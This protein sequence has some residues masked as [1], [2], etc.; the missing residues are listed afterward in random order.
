M[1]QLGFGKVVHRALPGL[2]LGLALCLATA[3]CGSNKSAPALPDSDAA[4]ADGGGDAGAAPSARVYVSVAADNQ[5][6]VIDEQ[7]QKLLKKV[8]V[9]MGPAILL[10][11]PDQKKLYTANWADNSVSAIVVDTLAVKNIKVSSRPYVIATDPAGKYLYAGLQ[12][13]QIDVIDIATDKIARSITT[14]D[15]PA[16]I[17]VSP[18]GKTLYVATFSVLGGLGGTV[19]AISADKGAVTHAS[20]A[21][22]SVPAWIS[23]SPDG[24]K[25]FT[26]NFLSDDI[27]VVDTAA[28]KV[29]ATVSTGAGSQ[30]IIGNVT[31]DGKTLYV[32]NH[33]THEL[34]AIDVKTN[35]VAQTIPLPGR[36]VGVSF[37][38]DGSRVYV[39]DFG[40]QSLNY[41]ADTNYLLTGKLTPHGNG[42]LDVFDTK[43]GK[44]IGKALM[45]GPGPTSVV[46]LP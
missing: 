12:A 30:A 6:A 35:K 3:A 8:D 28:W 7:R 31:P 13:N 11:T 46:V 19:R 21:V 45:L 40:P 29:T 27:S 1:V 37:N 15:Q 41:P 5:V 42:Q 18:D 9:G 32:T 36:P 2:A 44:R 25:V 33:G 10:A 23:M 4:A 17:I 43:T 14:P 34:M 16:S 38:S 26:L 24:D 22:G 39:A 20:I